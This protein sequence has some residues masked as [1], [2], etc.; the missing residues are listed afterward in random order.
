MHYLKVLLVL[1]L[2][3]ASMANSKRYLL[4]KI[5]DSNANAIQPL[6]GKIA[7]NASK[8][9]VK[10][11]SKKRMTDKKKKAYR[12]HYGTTGGYCYSGSR[13]YYY[14]EFMI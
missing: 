1:T 14:C 12:H 10:A 5:G 13:G 8:I 4:V 6:P 2:G 9:H 7:D 3:V 11:P